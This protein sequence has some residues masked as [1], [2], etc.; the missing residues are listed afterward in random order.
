MKDSRGR[1]MG[2]RTSGC[3]IDMVADEPG[4][5][6]RLR[7]AGGLPRLRSGAWVAGGCGP[8]CWRRRRQG[9]KAGG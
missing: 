9:R 4:G 6:R 3:R 2:L 8:A 7:L 1:H 5:Q